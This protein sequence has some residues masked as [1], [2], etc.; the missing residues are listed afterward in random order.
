M[1]KGIYLISFLLVCFSLTTQ[2]VA[3]AFFAGPCVEMV[4][5]EEAEKETDVEKDIEKE[6]FS[7]YNQVQ[8]SFAVFST[9]Y[10]SL[11]DS[12]LLSSP[13]DKDIIPPDQF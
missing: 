2:L 11:N 3:D 12:R 7:P 5:N 1:K 10:E 8:L 4:E 13:S 6:K 9:N